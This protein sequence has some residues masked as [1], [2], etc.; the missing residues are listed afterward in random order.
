MTV[1]R[2]LVDVGV[3]RAAEGW[4]RQ[5]G[6]D[7]QSVRDRDPRMED[8]DILSWAVNEQRLVVTMDKDFGE[9][10]FQFCELRSTL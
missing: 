10:V 3:G 7:T 1:L 5:H 4:L 9:L 8:A 6:H 2:V